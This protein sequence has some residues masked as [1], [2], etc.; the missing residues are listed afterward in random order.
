MALAEAGKAEWEN[1]PA[2]IH[3]WVRHLLANLHFGRQIFLDKIFNKS[4]VE[5]LKLKGFLK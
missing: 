5:L 4:L 2:G 1:C 3:L